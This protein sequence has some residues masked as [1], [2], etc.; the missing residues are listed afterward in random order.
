VRN[1][2]LLIGGGKSGRCKE[3]YAGWG[4]DTSFDSTYGAGEVA[5]GI[6]Y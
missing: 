4:V 6:A 3:W 5:V 2:V 1:A